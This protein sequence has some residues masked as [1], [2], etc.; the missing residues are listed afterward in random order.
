LT[1]NTISKRMKAV[2]NDFIRQYGFVCSTSS[3]PLEEKR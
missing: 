1:R 2:K 3:I